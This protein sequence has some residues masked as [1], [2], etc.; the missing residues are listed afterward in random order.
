MYN[1]VCIYSII[2]SSSSIIILLYIY[3]YYYIYIYKYDYIYIYILY[4]YIYYTNL[5]KIYF[6]IHVHVPGSVHMTCWP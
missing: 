2:I 3:K 1:Y 4:I 5:L 6:V